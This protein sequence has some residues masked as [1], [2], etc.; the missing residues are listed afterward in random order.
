MKLD[1]PE[2]SRWSLYLTT[3]VF[4]RRRED[5]N[6]EKK[7][8]LEGLEIAHKPKNAEGHRKMEEDR[9]DSPTGLL[10]GVWAG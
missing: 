7:A 6:T 9:T 10:E 8:M 3:S 4:I 5:K 1:H 2:L